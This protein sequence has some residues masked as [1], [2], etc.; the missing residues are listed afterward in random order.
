[1]SINGNKTVYLR[2]IGDE[3]TP[4]FGKIYLPIII[5][6]E[7]ITTKF[8]VVKSNCPIPHD[9]ILGHAFL[10][11]KTIINNIENTLTIK[12]ENDNNKLIK[13]AIT[14]ETSNTRQGD[15][16]ATETVGPPRIT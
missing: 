13:R 11:N 9:G 7:I 10:K 3:I 8:H 2:G 1:M 12:T 16:V 4:T 6:G 15:I 5:N 14:P